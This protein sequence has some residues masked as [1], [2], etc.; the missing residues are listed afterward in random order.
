DLGRN[1]FNLS[2]YKWVLEMHQRIHYV[3]SFHDF[4]AKNNDYTIVNGK[5]YGYVIIDDYSRFTWVFFLASKSE[6]L[7]VF[8]TFSKQIQNEKNSSIVTIRS[9]HM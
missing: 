6:A 2:I 9:D 3:N 5:Q 1:Y 8:I 7:D 4:Y